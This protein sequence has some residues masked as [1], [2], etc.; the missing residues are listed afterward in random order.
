MGFYSMAASRIH[1]AATSLLC[2]ETNDLCF[3]DLDSVTDNQN[4]GVT[5][6][7]RS[8]SL[9]DLPLLSEEVFSFMVES[10]REHL[11][12]EDYLERLRNGALELGSVRKE[13]IDWIWKACFLYGF[14]PLSVCLSVNYLDR[15]LALYEVPRDQTWAVQLLAV[16]CLS[17][18]TKME[19]PAVPL[20]V[21]LQVGEPKFMF[22]GKTIQR[23]EL[24]LLKT[25]DWKMKACTPFSFIDYFVRKINDHRHQPS[26]SLISRS[27]QLILSTIKGTDFL[28]FKHSEVA[29][30]VALHV[31][32]KIQPDDIP[33]AVSCFINL[34]VGRMLKCVEMLQ[35]LPLLPTI[36]VGIGASV[37]QSPIGVLDAAT[38]LNSKIDDLTGGSFDDS[39]YSTPETK[40]RKLDCNP[41]QETNFKS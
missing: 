20:N 5:D 18:A 6:E 27:V 1:C 2:E 31:S 22:E 26:G 23:M 36:N 30:A 13:A 34:E 39:S 11:P 21:D 15:F 38:S 41:S 10:E 8:E 25:L 29:A 37:P 7:D 17:L 35:D 14:G 24:L 3:D 9:V 32:G 33:N 40:R 16:T 19:E 12:R 4:L 28:E